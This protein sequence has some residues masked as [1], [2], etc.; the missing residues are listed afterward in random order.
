MSELPGKNMRP[1]DGG[2]QQERKETLVWDKT[3]QE[4]GEKR[5]NTMKERK[6]S[7]YQ[8]QM[9]AIRL[10]PEKARDTLRLLLKENRKRNAGKAKGKRRIRP[11]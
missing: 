10:S 7:A 1:V 6:R 11:P 5:M 9:D 3:A 4:K 2:L 8:I